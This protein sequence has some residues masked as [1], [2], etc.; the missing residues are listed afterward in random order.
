MR[1]NLSLLQN[2]VS[3]RDWRDGV[4]LYRAGAVS[5]LAR[6][7]ARDGHGFDVVVQPE[8]DDAALDVALLV[9]YDDEGPVLEEWQTP[10][11]DDTV[12]ARVVAAAIAAR[13]ALG[14]G[15]QDGQSG[16]ITAAPWRRVL[17][18]GSDSDDTGRTRERWICYDLTLSDRGEATEV[19][20]V[21]RERS[22]S[23]SGRRAHGS[24]IGWKPT[25]VGRHGYRT[26]DDAS[27]N[28]D[29]LVP[30]LCL[31]D[32]HDLRVRTIQPGFIDVFLRLFVDAPPY[33]LRID[34]EDAHVEAAA[35]GVAVV[36]E[37]A[38]DGGFRVR[39]RL[40][41]H[42]A[43]GTG[44]V[45]VLPG[46]VPWLY[47]RGEHAVVRPDTS[48]ASV[49]QLLRQG[50]V[51]VPSE[52]AE[53]FLEVALPELRSHVEV[54]ERSVRV[55]PTAQA[56]VQP[57]IE[58]GEVD[59]NLSVALRFAYP[60]TAH[61]K[62]ALTA[63]RDDEEADTTPGRSPVPI[64]DPGRGSRVF[65]RGRNA[66]GQVL[67]WQRSLEDEQQW[68][69]RIMHAT[70]SALPASLPLD[71]ALDFL[72][73]H[74]PAFE[75][76]GVD[77][78]GRDSLVS[79]G[80]QHR[81]VTPAVRVRSGIDWFGIDVTLS[82]GEHDLDV[83]DVIRAWR[84]GARYLRLDDGEVARLP[85]DWLNRHATAL[86]DLQEL[87]ERDDEHEVWKVDKA[88]APTLAD[89]VSEHAAA[90]A[91]WQGFVERLMNFEG[92][93]QQPLP[94][95]LDAEL[96]PYQRFGYD[97][98]ATLRE[99]GL[100]GCLADDM[101][102]G[103]TVQTLA[104]LQQQVESGQADG[105][106]LVVA[107][108]SVVTNWEEEAARFTPDLKVVVLC[109]VERE[110]RRRLLA[111]LG[112]AHIVVTSY[113]LLRIDR[114]QLVEQDFHYAVLDEA[115]AI[116]NPNSQTAR[117]ARALRARHRLALTGTPL[118]NNLLEL[119]SLFEFLMPGF[120][121]TRGRFVRRYGAVRD[122]VALPE[123]LEHLRRRLRPFVLRRLKRDVDKELPPLTEMT[124]RCE[125]GP[126]QR[127][128]YEQVRDTY[129]ARV[130]KLIEEVGVDRS[131]LSVLEALLRLRQAACHPNLLPF[132]EA[133]RVTTSAKTA[134]FLD[135]VDE[136]VSEGRRILVFSQWTSMLRLL[137][138]ELDELGIESCYMDGAT[139][140]RA[141]VIRRFQRDDGPPVFLISLKAGGVGLNLTAADVVIHY[142]P[143]W[144]PAVEQQA[145]DRAHRIG[146]DKPVLVLRLV[147]EQ[148]VEDQILRLQERKRQLASAAIEAEADGIKALSREDIELLFGGPIR[149]GETPSKAGAGVGL[150]P[151]S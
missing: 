88:L 108:T 49:L 53:A 50:S 13:E 68:L 101:G 36:V 78:H 106:S 62:R 149:P 4:T 114:E 56:S 104:A 118:E 27:K 102:L 46:P 141:R 137:R 17:L 44:D 23:D 1:L 97:W 112:D 93:E 124:L 28:R 100:H 43:G 55:P 131:A 16:E 32:R 135:K 59:G 125:L 21:R 72:I 30:V 126:E 77:V 91:A 24:V 54:V 31:V 82:A 85:V 41:S 3:G 22:Q 80:V 150:K 123:Q 96:R 144:N 33:T 107:P 140:D 120:F 86:I 12:D 29:D 15:R 25:P 103:K 35:R 117:A 128:L 64:F 92:V 47:L 122:G 6:R 83:S 26:S 76:E 18:A 116:K 145:S 69:E 89:L 115:Q 110:E 90:D 65:A 66:L 20:I 151:A 38:P 57:R 70:G 119:W 105:P 67:H 63:Y 45:V 39:A 60:P 95:G 142:D 42:H 34:G 127:K 40:Q 10:G 138:R 111:D 75:A 73:D 52:D 147:A 81:T 37:D 11:A 61:E 9:D 51:Q 5:R 98:L 84:S 146:Q 143:W 87:G 121:G 7:D 148:T 79:L 58:L 132:D 133:R 8:G 109:N 129:R 71:D 94:S 134:L 139:R 14:R 19:Q 113:A 99:L 136:L 130:L 74:L 2:C 48:L